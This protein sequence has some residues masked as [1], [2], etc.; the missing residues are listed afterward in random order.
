LVA[1]QIAGDVSRDTARD[2]STLVGELAPMKRDATLGSPIQSASSRGAGGN[3]PGVAPVEAR[4]S[5]RLIASCEHLERRTGR[6][7]NDLGIM[8]SGS[9]GSPT[10]VRWGARMW[11]LGWTHRCPPRSAEWPM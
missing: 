7:R 8:P 3:A 2:L 9:D 6:K 4:R 11:G 10:N 5:V 1:L